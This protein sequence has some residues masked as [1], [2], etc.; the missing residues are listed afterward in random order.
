MKQ[1][2][3]Q[4]KKK[5]T[6]HKTILKM[7]CRSVPKEITHIENFLQQIRLIKHIDDGMMHRLLVACTEA[8]NNAIVHGNESNPEKKVSIRCIVSERMLTICVADEGKGFDPDGLQDPRDEANL[9]KENGRGV[10]LM[11][12]L[13]DKVV[14][15]R[16][17]S[18]SVVELKVRL[19][20]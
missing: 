9:L 5:K 14:F 7:V 6:H 17:K 11:R 2:V 4:K 3:Q 12:S 8:V 15:K 19:D 18:G 10:F 1:S 16:L 13:M 20:R